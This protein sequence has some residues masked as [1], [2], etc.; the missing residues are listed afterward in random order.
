[1]LSYYN[2][3]RLDQMIRPSEE[4]HA[5]EKTVIKANELIQKSRFNLSLQQQ[6]IVL[7]LISQITPYDEEFKLYEFSIQ[8][9]CKVCGIDLGHYAELKEQIKIIADKSIWITLPN[10]KETLLRWI[11][12]PYVNERDGIIQ[13]KLDRDMKPYLLQLKEN[14]TSYELIWTLHFKSKYTIR[15]Y[16]LIKS[17]HFHD[18]E[19]Y[20][21]EYQVDELKK[22]LDAENYD[23]WIHFKQRVLDTAV[24]EINDF[25]DKNV[26]YETIRKGRSIDRVR[27]IITSKDTFETVELRDRIMKEMGYE[28]LTLWDLF[29]EKGI[30]KG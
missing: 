27:F 9:F 19:E 2:E 30:V 26:R 17:I 3:G 21:R 7:Y 18:L 10:G 20:K 1:M 22:L 24:N 23:R 6:K 29:K 11:E 28:Q 4:I 16:E 5:L 13:I 12:K 8:E 15:M 14:F 25:S